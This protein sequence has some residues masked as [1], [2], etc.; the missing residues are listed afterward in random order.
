M[1]RLTDADP[2]DVMAQWLEETAVTQY[3]Y[4]LDA[5]NRQQCARRMRELDRQVRDNSAITAF[6]EG[7]R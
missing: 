5:A 2:T 3:P 1:I 4:A 7:G 6:G